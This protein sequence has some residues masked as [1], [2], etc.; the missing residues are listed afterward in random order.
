VIPIK[1]SNIFSQLDAGRAIPSIQ[2]HVSISTTRWASGRTRFLPTPPTLVSSASFLADVNASTAVPEINI[3][4]TSTETPLL[5]SIRLPC[6][7]SSHTNSTPQLTRER[8]SST[9]AYS[10]MVNSSTGL[11]R[12]IS[13]MFV[14]LRNCSALFSRCT[15]SVINP[16][17]HF[18]FFV[19]VEIINGAG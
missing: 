16:S 12:L 4:V 1:L 14:S 18:A 2:L 10:S 19:V 9:L 11:K 13:S 15:C 3:M 6:L 8:P 5:S 7:L 17:K